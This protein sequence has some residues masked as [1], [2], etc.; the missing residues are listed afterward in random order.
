MANGQ[1]FGFGGREVLYPVAPRFVNGLL[2]KPEG[3]S[4][5]LEGESAGFVSCTGNPNTPF[6]GIADVKPAQTSNVV[7][8]PTAAVPAGMRCYLTRVDIDVQGNTAWSVTSPT[9]VPYVTVQD[10]NAN[11]QIYLP[12]NSL[13]G[14]AGYIFPDSDAEV[15]LVATASSYA[16]STGVITLPSSTL[17]GSSTAL[18]GTPITVIGGTGIGQSAIINTY[19]AT[20]ITPVGGA[21]AFPVALDNTSVIA[22]WYWQAT[23]SPTSTTIPFSNASFTSNALDNG[24]SLVSVYGT[25]VGATRPVSSNTSTTPTV[26]YAFNTSAVAGDLIHITNNPTLFGALDLALIDKWAS[27]GVGKGIQ[28]AV[29]V[30]GG[31]S[32]VGS[33]LRVYVE[34]FFAP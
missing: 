3:S 34:G 2:V 30:G 5:F 12:F 18:K 23:G 17:I 11:P 4:N 1:L 21:S 28:V 9:S 8:I 14:L 16:A 24:F 10:D 19:T 29:N 26:A 33:P 22:V 27:S 15:P 25:S 13:R 31:T 6:F 20:S 7:M 32:P